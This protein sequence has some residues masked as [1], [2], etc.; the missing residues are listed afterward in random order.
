MLSVKLC[1]RNG[2]NALRGLFEKRDMFKKMK[3][4]FKNVRLMNK[5][6]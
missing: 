3:N 2:T 1:Q 6:A 4:E 5:V